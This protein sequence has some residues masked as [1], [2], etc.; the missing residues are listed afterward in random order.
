MLFQADANVMLDFKRAATSD[1]L[2]N[3]SGIA[4]SDDK[5]WAV[6]DEGRSLECLTRQGLGYSLF[7][8]LSLDD[9]LTDLPGQADDELDL[10]SIDITG[11]T[12]WICGSHCRVRKKPEAEGSLNPKLRSRPSRH[13][14]AALHLDQ[15]GNVT[16]GSAIPFEGK[17]SLRHMLSDDPYLKPFLE[18]P[19]KENGLDIEGIVADTG[20]VLLG[21]RGPLVDSIAVVIRL[22]LYG[23]DIEGYELSFLDLGGLAIRDL[24]RTPGGVLVLAGPV[25]DVPGP[26][27]LYQWDGSSG[28]NIQVPREVCTWPAGVEKPEG[29]CVYDDGAEAKLL[30][31][32]DRPQGRIQQSC[33]RADVAALASFHG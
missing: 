32:Y 31:V 17:G 28:P 19:S 22:R 16:A 13:V 8:Q 7:Y 10:E 18:L 12:L 1:I 33:Y 24:A 29:I 3:L 14:L 11:S 21:L 30:V 15:T 4:A 27:R 5:L 26:F 23:L 20:G 9:I 2:E 25:S 6:A